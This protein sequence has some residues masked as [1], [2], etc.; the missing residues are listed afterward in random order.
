MEVNQ[1]DGYGDVN[2]SCGTFSLPRSSSRGR[3]AENDGEDFEPAMPTQNCG[4]ANDRVRRQF[5]LR[6]ADGHGIHQ[7]G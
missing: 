5:S 1:A 7:G 3:V 6:E 2:K 4:P